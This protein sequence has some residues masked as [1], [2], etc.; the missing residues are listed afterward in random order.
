MRIQPP[1]TRKRKFTTEEFREYLFNHVVVGGEKPIPF[2]DYLN[3]LIEK[4]GDLKKGIEAILTMLPAPYYYFAG[5]ILTNEY[6]R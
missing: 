6:L 5:H 1:R 4:E 2:L 3:F